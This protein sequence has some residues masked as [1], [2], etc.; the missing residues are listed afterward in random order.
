MKQYDNFIYY[1]K[2]IIEMKKFPPL[3]KRKEE[4][5]DEKEEANEK[6]S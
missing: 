6:G 1:V 2:G 5:E 3:Q 4:Y